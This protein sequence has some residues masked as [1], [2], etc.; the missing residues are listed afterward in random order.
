MA[1]NTIKINDKNYLL[2]NLSDR[3]KELIQS[4]N[5]ADQQIEQLN[6]EW[7]IAD[8]ARIA[9]TRALKSS[10]EDTKKEWT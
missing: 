3:A 7:A 8:T 5:F 10:V 2:E 6:N 4:I 9:Y 1:E